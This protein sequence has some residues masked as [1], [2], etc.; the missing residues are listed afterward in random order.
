M[1]LLVVGD[2]HG[3]LHT[4]QK[5]LDEHWNP[6]EEVLVQLGDLIDRGKHTPG[7]LRLVWELKERYGP[8]AVFLK[9]NHE[10]EFV[11]HIEHGPNLYWLPQGGQDT[12]DQLEAAQVKAQEVVNWIGRLPLVWED[13]YLFISHAGIAAQAEYPFD[14]GNEQGVLWNRAPLKNLGRLQIFGHTPCRSGRPEY[15]EASHFWNIDTGAYRNAA[16]SAI[17]V[18]P[19]GEVL[20]IISCPVDARDVEPPAASS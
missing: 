14:E 18:T 2:V 17:R 7:T 6:E 13:E 5:L 9:G 16:L 10:Y 12:L 4:F 20:E 8:Q 15:E 1:N 3:C 19:F 11:Q